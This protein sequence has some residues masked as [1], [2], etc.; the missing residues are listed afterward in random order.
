MSAN[1]PASPASSTGAVPAS[2]RT[3]IAEDVLLLLL[4][5]KSGSIRG[6][7]APLFHTLAGAVLTDLAV[8]GWVTIDDRTT[9]RGRRVHA[10]SSDEAGRPLDGPA[11]PLLRGTWERLVTRPT[12]VYSLILEIGPTLRAPMIDRLAER[13]HIRLEAKKLL[14]LIPNT[15]IIDGGTPHRADLLAPVRAVLVDGAEPDPH[16]AAVVALLSASNQLPAM[17]PEIPWS[18][19]V[20][21]RGVAI[22]KGDWGANAAAVAVARTTAAI[23]STA[24]FV[25]L[26]A[27]TTN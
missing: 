14:G 27:P 7:G 17:H 15:T 20:Y 6:E 21:T 11:D 3:L 18:G 9:L 10:V 13:G 26:T 2:S 16:T 22:Q 19:A 12:D 1:T 5:P 4:E 23:L 25:S 8:D 24:L